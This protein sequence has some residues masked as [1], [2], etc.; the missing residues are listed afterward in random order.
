[1]QIWHRHCIGA[2][3]PEFSKLNKKHEQLMSPNI[4]IIMH[5]SINRLSA[6]V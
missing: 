5:G 4:N 1:M 2:G 6:A 3:K